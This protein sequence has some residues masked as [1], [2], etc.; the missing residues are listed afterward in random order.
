[1][2]ICWFFMKICR[3]KTEYVEKIDLGKYGPLP[4][5]ATHVLQPQPGIG[6]RTK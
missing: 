6:L 3:E 2:N 5:V 4:T 1:M